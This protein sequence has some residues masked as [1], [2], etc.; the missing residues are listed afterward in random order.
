MLIVVCIRYFKKKRIEIKCY[1][2]LQLTHS[3][4]FVK[5]VVSA[6][7]LEFKKYLFSIFII[8]IRIETKNITK[9]LIDQFPHNKSSSLRISKQIH[10]K[11]GTIYILLEHYEYTGKKRKNNKASQFGTS[12]FAFQTQSDIT[13]GLLP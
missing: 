10:F 9:K 8:I 6:I 3:T 12:Q 13:H 7:K 11:S 1:I 4:T 2:S 5:F